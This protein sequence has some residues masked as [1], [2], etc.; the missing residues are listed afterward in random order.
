M[1]TTKS[2]FQIVI[3]T[4]KSKAVYGD[5]DGGEARSFCRQGLPKELTSEWRFESC[6]K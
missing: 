1:S 6:K 3:S 4:I 5:S 2:L